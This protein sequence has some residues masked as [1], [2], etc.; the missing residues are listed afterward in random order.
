MPMNKIIGAIGASL[1]AGFALGA[2]MLSAP[3]SERAP[4]P[5]P[6]AVSYFDASA[7]VSERIRALELAVGEERNARQLLEEELQVLMDEIERISAD[8]AQA[9]PE[10]VANS[11]NAG[12]AQSAHES[13]RQRRNARRSPQA[14]TEEL[15]NAGLA[16]DRAALIAQRES[17]LQMEA[18]QARFEARRAGDPFNFRD[19]NVNP[20][21]KLRAEIG[22]IEYEMFLDAS[23]RPT[24]VTVSGVLESSPAQSAGLQ[25]GDQIV[26]Y[27]GQR[28]FNVR[29]LTAQTL[30]GAPGQNVVVDIK[31]DG[32]P[33]Q[34][35][36]PRGP[37][38]IMGG[39]R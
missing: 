16:P 23:N 20:D 35:V 29:E 9:E 39:R 14:R 37:L 27:D 34:V 22:D 2:W 8:G 24:S 19:A 3:D 18:M 32:I 26:R 5:E 12:D 33:M 11:R 4:T 10:R 21:A 7:D 31:R 17:E 36:L 1:V 6:E 38:G 15:I 28:V 30:Q 13:F 25:P